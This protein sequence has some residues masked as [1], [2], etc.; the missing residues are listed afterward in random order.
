LNKLQ[1]CFWLHRGKDGKGS[2]GDWLLVHAICL[3]DMCS[4]LG[5]PSSTT[6]DGHN[7]RIVNI[8]V[9]GDTMQS[10]CSLRFTDG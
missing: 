1:L 10:L 9:L 6:E 7:T 4:S 2:M 5:L 8:Q 3:R